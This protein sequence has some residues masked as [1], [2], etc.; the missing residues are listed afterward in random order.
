MVDGTD[1]DWTCSIPAHTKIIPLKAFDSKV[2][3]FRC[4]I[5]INLNTVDVCRESA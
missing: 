4:T 1:S 2:G 5:S 3:V